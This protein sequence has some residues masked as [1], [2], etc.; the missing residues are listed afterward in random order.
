MK[1]KFMFFLLIVSTLCFANSPFD[2]KQGKMKSMTDAA[3]RGNAR[4]A[5]DLSLYY[6][7]SHNITAEANKDDM[8][9]Y[10]L[11]IAAE[12]DTTGFYM[13]ELS[14][15]LISTNPKA[16]DRGLYWLYLSSEK[17]NKDA[18]EDIKNVYNNYNFEFADDSDYSD[19][20]KNNIEDLMLGA[21]H[22][23]GKAALY[24]YT[25]FYSMN[26]IVQAEYWI[27]IGAQNGS[28]ECMKKYAILLKQSSDTYDNMR[29][30]FWEKRSVK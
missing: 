12:N 7:Y 21:L 10:W 29:S 11:L 6:E 27:R 9:L 26:K 13:K 22:G 30:K 19:E 4:A 28:K 17:G 24:L 20:I 15:Y 18:A 2:I 23:S 5:N 25:H 1:N 14:S 16:I 8:V 3:L